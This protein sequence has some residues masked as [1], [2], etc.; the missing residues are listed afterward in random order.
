MLPDLFESPDIVG[1][2]TSSAAS[3]AGLKEGTPVVIG[4]GDGAC[5]TC[6]AGVVKKGDSYICLGTSTWMATASHEPFIDPQKRTF[7]FH[8]STRDFT[9]PVEPCRRGGIIEVVQGYAGGRGE[10]CVRGSAIDVYDILNSKAG[11]VP[12]GSDGLVF[13]PYLMG[14]R[15]PLWNA[16]ARGSFVGLS[17]VH[18]KAHMIRSVMEGVAYNMKIIADAFRELGMDFSLFRV[19]GGGAR[20]RVWLQIFADILERPTA[21]LNYADE[22]TS[23]GAAIAGGVG[24]GLFDSIE[25]ADRFIQ[26]VDTIP[27]VTEHFAVHRR[28]YPIFRTAYD[29]LVPVF[30]M[31]AGRRVCNEAC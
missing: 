29:Q 16:D 7:T 1:K 25:Q 11:S 20:S 27:P 12:P 9:S 28:Q 13:L 15:S 30:E 18:R 5:A 19:I 3:A 22:A 6:G 26:I 10:R 17:M 4:S 24:I 23:I 21:T 8:T 2:V 14:E 31:M